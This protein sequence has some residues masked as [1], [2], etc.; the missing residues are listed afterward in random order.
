MVPASEPEWVPGP[1]C[2]GSQPGVTIWGSRPSLDP[3]A[4]L[5]LRLLQE[6]TK[7]GGKDLRARRAETGSLDQAGWHCTPV[8][9]L[10]TGGQPYRPAT[11]QAQVGGGQ[12]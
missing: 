1:R 6:R 2:C 5:H 11:E 8:V 3:G 9:L 12:T 10:I 7:L 4:S